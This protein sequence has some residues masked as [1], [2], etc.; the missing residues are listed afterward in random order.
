M[1]A[2]V[3]EEL[4]TL[5]Q[6]LDELHRPITVEQVR[7]SVGRATGSARLVSVPLDDGAPVRD[8]ATKSRM[9]WL[10]VAAVVVV[11][12][13]V[14]SLVWWRSTETTTRSDTPPSLPASTPLQVG[15][16]APDVTLDLL[17]TGTVTLSQ[18]RGLWLVLGFTYEGCEP[19]SQTQQA[20][21]NVDAGL[22]ANRSDVRVITVG[23]GADDDQL[24]GLLADSA[25]G[26]ATSDDGALMEAFRPQQFPET[27]IIDPGGIVAY[28]AI[29]ALTADQLR[30]ELTR[31]VTF[32]PATVLPGPPGTTLSV[33]NDDNE[34]TL[35]G[36]PGS[37]PTIPAGG[38]YTTLDLDRL[39]TGWQVDM[40]GGGHPITDPD[41]AGYRWSTRLISDDGDQVDV[42]TRYGA[43]PFTDTTGSQHVVDGRLAT[44]RDG[45]MLWHEPNGVLVSIEQPGAT[46][47]E[48]IALRTL[49]PL[50][51]SD[52]LPPP[53]QAGR[54]DQPRGTAM[55]SGT[56][57]G[58]PW[59][60]YS[61][62]SAFSW[63]AADIGDD[64]DIRGAGGGSTTPSTRH[65]DDRVWDLDYLGLGL[66]GV[67]MWGIAPAG[68]DR[69][70][71]DTSGGTTS[72]PVAHDQDGFTL[73]VIP[74]PTATPVQR[75]RFL[76]ADGTV[77]HT[78]IPPQFP[79]LTIDG[80]AS[81]G[82]PFGNIDGQ[83]VTTTG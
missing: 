45:A 49:L 67:L 19:C 70:E 35:T 64:S 81:G 13:G 10:A 56:I 78:A 25:T 82:L 48:L 27:W 2:E 59:K 46:R 65:P 75:F 73:F 17:D 71:I 21:A 55:L 12:C 63:L 52:Q 7:R 22:A 42:M 54:A 40:A 5:G 43:D 4:S 57:A 26:L 77:V 74:N 3:L 76:T 58:T 30:D 83:H 39:P 44:F 23:V 18:L 31:L 53:P 36:D 41:P 60:L 24:R 34:I 50:T 15:E 6:A 47:D 51:S 14:A 68:I 38:A 69:L 16:E 37:L 61:E 66:E 79:P 72:V 8:S 32:Q 33:V 62:P 20:W 29:G 1:S 28:H 11:M 9:S 80:T